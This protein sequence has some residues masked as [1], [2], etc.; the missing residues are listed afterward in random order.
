MP[1]QDDDHARRAEKPYA[2]RTGEG[3]DEGVAEARESP[4]TIEQYEGANTWGDLKGISLR[5]LAEGLVR[6][7]QRVVAI[8]ARMATK[9]DLEG[10]VTKHD[11]TRT[12]LSIVLWNAGVVLAG[13]AVMAGVTFGILQ[14]AVS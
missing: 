4:I 6:I 11:L 2:G 13:A 14:L 5:K 1:E 3:T 10:M 9:K 12:K 7:E 8:E